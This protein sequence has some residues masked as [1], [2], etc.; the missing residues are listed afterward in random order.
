VNEHN[1]K[2]LGYKLELNMFADY[3]DEEFKKMT[4]LLPSD[5]KV[6][7]SIPFPHSLEELEQMENELPEYFDMRFDG[8]MRPVRSE[9]I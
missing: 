6:E 9:L 8:N 2:N 1:R 7:G 5:P 3:T 4:G